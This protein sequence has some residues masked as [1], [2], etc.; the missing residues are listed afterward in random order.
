MA[1]TSRVTKLISSPM[2]KR[3]PRP[4][5]YASQAERQAAYRARNV[6]LEFRA[7]PKTADNI[8]KIADT[9]GYP[10]SDV[11]LSMVKFARTN[12]D[13]ARFGLTHKTIPTYKENPMHKITIYSLQAKYLIRDAERIEK[14]AQESSKAWIIAGQ[15][16]RYG[17]E[18]N[19]A[20][21]LR[22][23][24]GTKS[25]LLK[26]EILSNAGFIV[27]SKKNLLNQNPTMK[28]ASPAQLA[29]RKRFAEMARSGAFKKATKRKANPN[30]SGMRYQIFKS[31]GPLDS[32]YKTLSQMQSALDEIDRKPSGR[33]YGYD[34]AF[35]RTYHSFAHNQ[36]SAVMKNNP[37]HKYTVLHRGTA[38]VAGEVTASGPQAAKQKVAEKL[39]IPTLAY[40]VAKKTNPAKKTVSQKISQLRHEGYPQRQ[41]VA[42]ALSE[43]RAGKLKRNPAKTQDIY[44]VSIMNQDGLEYGVDR[45]TPVTYTFSAKEPK[46]AYRS[47]GLPFNVTSNPKFQ[48]FAKRNKTIVASLNEIVEMMQGFA[49]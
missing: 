11:L 49:K 12:H 6:M 46:K 22:Q 20:R 36:P 45:R 21:L 3:N 16:D 39:G 31:N 43:Q 42:V 17:E 18:M 40:L 26:K 47:F 34:K 30:E 33:Y 14:Y 15:Y 44:F 38:N 19:K 35:G 4:R 5:K 7:E 1:I 2:T 48:E 32:E 29:A 23:A 9:L 24:A 41:A 8:S 25:A 10:R 28:P 37:M 27:K 13:W